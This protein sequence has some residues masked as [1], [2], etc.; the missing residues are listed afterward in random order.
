MPGSTDDKARFSHVPAWRKEERARLIAARLEISADVRTGHAAR[1]AEGLDRQIGE[2]AGRLVSLYWPFR[3]EPDLRGWAA[4]IIAR[5]GR[6]ALPVVV[7]KARPL[8]FR[9]WAPGDPLERGIWNIPIPAAGE[10][11]M[12]DIV[13]SPVVGFDAMNYRLGYGGGFYDRTLAAMPAKPLVIGVGY[14]MQR[15]DTINPQPFDIPMDVIVT[16]AG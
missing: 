1:I 9:Q 7:E 14:A 8:I 11:V 3:G 10:P 13:V 5:G 2:V 16:E 15:I 12:P 4:E 6:I